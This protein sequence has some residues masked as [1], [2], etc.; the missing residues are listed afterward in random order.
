MH[1]CLPHADPGLQLSCACTLV[2]QKDFII[3]Q[4]ANKKG[5]HRTCLT[6]PGSP[7]SKHELNE[8]VLCQHGTS[9]TFLS[10]PAPV[11]KHLPC[12]KQLNTQTRFTPRHLLTKGMM[13]T[14]N[15]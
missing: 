5:K 14:D 9:E 2:D 15:I 12:L 13:E 6:N 8:R 1:A 3:K 7:I 10:A 4:R 11:F